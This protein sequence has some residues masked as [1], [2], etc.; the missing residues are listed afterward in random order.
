MQSVKEAIRKPYSWPGGYP[1]SIIMDD[2]CAICPEC[3]KKEFRQVAH[4]TVK[5]WKRTG[6]NATAVD[7]L[8]EGGSYCDNCNANLD[9]YPSE[10]MREE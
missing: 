9:A 3:A 4:D 2:G 8:W 7:V 1:L 6:W 10:E 5:G